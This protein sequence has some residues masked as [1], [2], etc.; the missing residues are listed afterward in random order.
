MSQ[1]IKILSFV[2]IRILNVRN[3]A[4]IGNTNS[5]KREEWGRHGKLKI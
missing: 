2:Y 4:E 1:N 3:S 5:N